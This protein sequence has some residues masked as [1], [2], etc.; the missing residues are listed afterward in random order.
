LKGLLYAEPVKGGE[1]V[2]AR[3]G[4]SVS[5]DPAKTTDGES[6]KVM[7]NLFEGLV[8]YK[9]NSTEIEP[10][11]AVSW[12]SS[13]DE[14]EWTF[15]LRK[16]VLFH[17]GTVFNAEAVVFS[18]MRQIDPNHP[19]YQKDLGSVLKYVKTVSATGE[20]SVRFSLTQ[21]YAPFLSNLGMNF[22]S[23]IVSP[24]GLKK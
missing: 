12:E 17:D 8:R 13:P 21:P 22:V 23:S 10:C 19:F 6:V 5:L 11:L 7:V 3:G 18:F 4:E 14:K 15:Q 2:I 20:Y 9:D 1:L 24:S 16:G